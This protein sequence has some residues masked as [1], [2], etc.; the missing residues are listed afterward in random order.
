MAPLQ[1]AINVSS[2]VSTSC[3]TDGK[4]AIKA[5]EEKQSASEPIRL[6]QKKSLQQFASLDSEDVIMKVAFLAVIVV[7]LAIQGSEA[8]AGLGDGIALDLIIQPILRAVENLLLGQLPVPAGA[9]PC[10]LVEI[11]PSITLVC[12]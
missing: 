1:A 2:A 7:V 11:V 9:L 8:L 12:T 3:Q 4:L 10:G 5:T 6:R